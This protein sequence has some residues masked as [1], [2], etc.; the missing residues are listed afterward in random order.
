M[1][2]PNKFKENLFDTHHDDLLI[3]TVGDTQTGELQTIKIGETDVVNA[4]HEEMKETLEKSKNEEQLQMPEDQKLG[5]IWFQRHMYDAESENSAYGKDYLNM[6]EDKLYGGPEPVFELLEKKKGL[7]KVT[8]NHCIMFYEERASNMSE[9]KIIMKYLFPE[10]LELRIE[11]SNFHENFLSE[12]LEA[13]P[14]LEKLVL[15]DYE[16]R[17]LDKII[18]VVSKKIQAS[19]LKKLQVSGNLN[20][21]I[22]EQKERE[23]FEDELSNLLEILGEKECLRSLD[24]SNNS[25]SV[26]FIDKALNKLK[27]FK[28][29]KS[30]SLASCYLPYDAFEMLIK[31]MPFPA[32]ERLNFSHNDFSFLD[33]TGPK[34]VFRE[35]FPKLKK[36]VLHDCS[37][38]INQ[39]KDVFEDGYKTLKELDLSNNPLG[40]GVFQAL[41][42]TT[43]DYLFLRNCN[44]EFQNPGA[45]AE[46][47]KFKHLDISCQNGYW[48]TEVQQNLCAFLGK[49]FEL[50]ENISKIVCF[51]VEIDLNAHQKLTA[52]A[53]KLEFGLLLKKARTN[54]GKIK[55]EFV[56]NF[57]RE[58]EEEH[59][60]REKRKEQFKKG[61]ERHHRFFEGLI[62]EGHAPDGIKYDAPVSGS[63]GIKANKNIH[64]GLLI[65]QYD[66]LK[67]SNPGDKM[68]TKA[69]T[70]VDAL[71]TIQ[72]DLKTLGINVKVQKSTTQQEIS[73]TIVRMPQTEAQNLSIIPFKIDALFENESVKLVVNL[74]TDNTE[75]NLMNVDDR[76]QH[77]TRANVDHIVEVFSYLNFHL[78][79]FNF[80]MELTDP[81]SGHAMVQ[82]SFLPLYQGH[83]RPWFITSF[84]QIMIILGILQEERLFDRFI[85]ED[86]KAFCDNIL[87]KIKAALEYY[88]NSE[89]LCA[90]Y[91]DG[92]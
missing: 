29:I 4:E 89:L 70:A 90:L 13:L 12:L 78:T 3:A 28:K 16:G 73:G 54:H 58:N 45:L 18:A 57:D 62:V 38:N 27:V 39:L 74:N 15:K 64:Q 75:D 33:D 65:N 6:I 71:E 11:A 19:K 77:V 44:L 68:L 79:D 76:S 9:K 23:T 41:K 40:D 60:H 5:L 2:K 50:N 24:L 87:L 21:G 43:L 55:E 31:T 92:Q 37:L 72:E 36:L 35:V 34:I 47:T 17:N 22:K 26:E 48:K 63:E 69:S 84:D 46:I 85:I 1:E 52:H 49:A 82:V 51:G 20:S 53:K 42:N 88:T 14:N 83:S 81:E 91:E 8:F 25:L 10:I 59:W 80:A 56:T 7:K 67:K 86:M 61:G 30:L 32:I 66:M